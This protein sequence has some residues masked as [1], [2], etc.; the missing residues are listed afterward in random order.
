MYRGTGSHQV[1]GRDASDYFEVLV[2]SGTGK[3]GATA[4]QK[5]NLKLKGDDP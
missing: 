3:Q 5:S 2:H 4:D 1:R